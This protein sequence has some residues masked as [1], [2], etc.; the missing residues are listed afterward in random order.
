MPS[1][2]EKVL[3]FD[4]PDG[5]DASKFDDWSFYSGQ[6]ARV[7]DAEILCKNCGGVAQ[8]GQ[9]GTKRIAGTRG[10][11]ILA[12][13]TGS[14]C[15][16][17]EIKDDRST[18]QTNFMFLADMVALKVRDTHACLVAARLDANDDSERDR[19]IRALAC[20]HMRVVLHL[21]PPPSHRPL[22]SPK[23]QRANVLQRLK[24]LVKAVDPRP[25]V[26]SMHD[27]GDLA[28]SVTQVGTP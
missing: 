21:E 14:V 6:F 22:L 12:V 18:R 23:M 26:V 4:F 13:D 2:T 20:S 9:C 17:I 15:W 1:I 10:I 19:A 7:G 3:K 28:W 16:H 8:C 11:D 5:W 25:L 24:Q 27:L